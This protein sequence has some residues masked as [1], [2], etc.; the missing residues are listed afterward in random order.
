MNG[1]FYSWSGGNLYSH[2]T[3]QIRNNYYGVQY[4]STITG[5][6]NVEPKTIKLFKTMSYESDDRVGVHIFNNRLRYR[7]YAIYIFCTKRRRVVY[8]S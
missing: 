7:V 4:K 5:V 3:N 2:N 8:F 1:F 6:L